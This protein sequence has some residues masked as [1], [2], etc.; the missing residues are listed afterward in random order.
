M[1][2]FGEIAA[3]KT[4]QRRSQIR[5]GRTTMAAARKVITTCA[6]TGS[7]HT[8]TMTPHLPI[9]P[10][11]IARGI[12]S[13]PPRPAPRSS[14]CTRAIPKDGKPTP[15]PEGVHAVPAAHQA[16][17][18]TRCVNITTGGGHGMTLQERLA[19]ALA[20]QPGDGAPATWAR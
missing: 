8:P 19:G 9:T 11:E 3:S 15:D 10:D 12:R 2:G 17:R 5:G 16:G 1:V 14:I 13:A 4:L 18:P 7:I 20:R 6:V